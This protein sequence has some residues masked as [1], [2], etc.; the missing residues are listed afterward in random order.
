MKRTFTQ[1]VKQVPTSTAGSLDGLSKSS[2]GNDP[3]GTAIGT[4]GTRRARTSAAMIGLAISMG[5][6]GLLLPQQ[7]D[8]AMAVEPIA[9]EPTLTNLPSTAE[10]IVSAP[11]AAQLEV[12]SVYKQSTP[13]KPES[14]REKI[15]HPPVVEHKVGSGETLWQLSKSYEVQP[16]AIAASNKNVESS[17]ALSPGKT[18]KI[19]SVNGIVHEVKTGESVQTLSKSYGVN[20]TQVHTLGS[21]SESEQLPRGESVTVSGKVDD[22]LKARQD[23]GID[24]L[25]E[26][27]NRLNDSLS[28]LQSEESSNLSKLE[29]AANNIPSSAT[30]LKSAEPV[31]S[32]SGLA[33]KTVPSLEIAASPTVPSKTDSQSQSPAVI[34]VLTPEI[35]VSPATIQKDNRQFQ[36]P[37]VIP[38]PT[39]E[40]AASPTVPLKASSQPQSSVVMPVSAPNTA[41]SMAVETNTAGKYPS[42]VAIPVPTPETAIAIPLP[43]QPIT[44]P[45]AKI[46]PVTAGETL[47]KPRAPQP[48]VM[49]TVESTGSGN[50]YRVKPGDTLGSIA[51]RYGLSPSELRQANGL[52]NPNLIRVNQALKIP[53][54]TGTTSDTVTFIPGIT[55]NSNTSNSNNSNS[56]NFNSNKVASSQEQRA[57]ASPSLVVS[58]I[59]TPISPVVPTAGASQPQAVRSTL[60]AE[61]NVG[62]VTANFST[63]VVD[64]GSTQVADSRSNPY[65]ERLRSDILRVREEYRR[66]GATGE[67][68]VPSNIVVPAAPVAPRLDNRAVSTITNPEFNPRRYELET[69]QAS[70]PINVPPPES[71]FSTSQQQVAVAP[72]PPGNYNPMLQTPV[73]E[74]VSPELPPLSAPD[75]YLPGSPSQFN[76]YIWPSKGVL[77]SGYG[78]RWGRMHKGI[79]IAAPIGTP[80]VAAAD[81]V[82]VSAGWNSG[83]YGNLVEVQHADG[84]VT[85]YAHNNRILVRQGQEV[86]QGQQISE[87]GSTGFSTGPHLH[88]EVHPS[89]GAAVNPMA[90]LPKNR[91]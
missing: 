13:A 91:S 14:G 30:S 28:Q 12:S 54:A 89:G 22:L 8:E 57:I 77:T 66:Q 65:V 5:A 11:P 21:V 48:V 63:S 45:N 82:V 58:S 10:T 41:A 50:V 40:T 84:S 6:S 35:A 1:K 68:N 25:K 76:G 23:N 70:I 38:V 47:A 37:V 81:G 60:L 44:I 32:I 87:M 26:Q 79:D 42:G 39:P 43:P 86:A 53:G 31:T 9:T 16:E 18:L 24:S 15:T 61:S 55:S 2:G 46:D 3:V 17:T 64:S 49:E 71:A 80:V 19:P 75:N 67:A 52:S 78:P 51:R 74:T 85:R 83:G 27:R 29:T 4:E 34:P 20:P 69:Q 36:S 90:F 88:F 72:A 59:P 56:N 73:G 33:G 7:G 62:G